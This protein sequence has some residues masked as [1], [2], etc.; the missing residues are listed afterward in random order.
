MFVLLPFALCVHQRNNR[1]PFGTSP[2]QLGRTLCGVK[3]LTEPHYLLI[4]EPPGGP[5]GTP[6][7][8]GL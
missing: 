4:A 5:Q 1:P 2:Q 8:L 3:S 6:V 7:R